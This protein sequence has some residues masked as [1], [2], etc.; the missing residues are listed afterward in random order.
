MN[1]EIELGD[2]G[3]D[4]CPCGEY[5]CEDYYIRSHCWRT[6]IECCPFSGVHY[7]NAKG[8]EHAERIAEHIR[9]AYRTEVNISIFQ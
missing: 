1:K 6:G 3:S 7:D 9:G 5:K 2:I 4:G 8:K